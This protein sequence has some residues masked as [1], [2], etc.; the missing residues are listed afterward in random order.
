METVEQA[1]QTIY[2]ELT[3][4][5]AEVRAEFLK[6]FESKSRAFSESMSQAF[7]A[8]LALDAMLQED[9]KRGPVS[10]FVYA[11]VTLHILSLKLL[12]SGQTVAA[13]NFI[14]QSGRDHRVGA[15]PPSIRERPVLIPAVGRQW[16]KS[17]ARL[18]S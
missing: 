10:Q 11:A 3:A 2:Q 14:A 1:Q 5:D 7:V 15:A 8:W 17:T 4:D 6:H 9:E 16:G 18:P 13:G 12:L